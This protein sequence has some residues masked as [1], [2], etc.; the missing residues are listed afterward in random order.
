MYI[1]EKLGIPEDDTHHKES[2]SYTMMSINPH[3]SINQAL[4]M[5]TS[6]LLLEDLHH[7][8]TANVWAHLIRPRDHIF[9]SQVLTYCVFIYF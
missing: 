2:K 5:V 3:I 4:I 7:R 6:D 1:H 8:L 9:Q